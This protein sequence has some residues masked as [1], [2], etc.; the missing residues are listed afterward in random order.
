[1]PQH[2][3]EFIPDEELMLKIRANDASAFKALFNRYYRPLC[4]FISVYHSDDALAEEIVSDVFVSFWELRHQST[5]QSVKNYLFI[6][7]RNQTFNRL[8]KKNAPLAYY[9]S[10][11]VYDNV[12][13]DGTSPLSVIHSRETQQE[14]ISLI[15]KL[16]LRQKEILLMSRINGIENEEIAS[17]LGISLKTVQSTLY[18]A[19]RELRTKL[20]HSE[21]S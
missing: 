8:R 17:M 21:R 18:E 15:N 3:Y 9:D 12:L 14:I 1:M 7:A 13:S 11:E 20:F 19:I 2:E 10:L 5:I 16:P 4:K 6:A